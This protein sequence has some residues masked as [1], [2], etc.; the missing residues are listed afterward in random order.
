M[1]RWLKKRQQRA[2]LVEVYRVLQAENERF[3]GEAVRVRRL[4]ADLQDFVTDLCELRRRLK[5]VADVMSG[6]KVRP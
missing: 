3:R 6:E 4:E 2:H 5:E 1:F